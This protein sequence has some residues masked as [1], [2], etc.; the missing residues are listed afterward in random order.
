VL[1]ATLQDLALHASHA[2]LKLPWSQVDQRRRGREQWYALCTRIGI[3]F[4][5]LLERYAARLAARGLWAEGSAFAARI[6][7]GVVMR[8]QLPGARMLR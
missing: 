2:V 1:V 8:A 5:A 3:E 6:S 4:G 7:G